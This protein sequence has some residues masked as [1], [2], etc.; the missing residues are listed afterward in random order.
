MVACPNKNTKDWKDLVNQIGEFEAYRQYISNNYSI[1]ISN[2]KQI[3]ELDEYLT[4]LLNNLGF[5]VKQDSRLLV[6]KDGNQLN[7][8]ARVNFLKKLVEVAQGRADE[9]T[10]PEES[11]HIIVELLGDDNLLIKSMM[12]KI[13]NYKLYDTTF[14]EYKS[15]PAYLNEDGTPNIDKIKK[16]AIGKL[17]AQYIVN[18]YKGEE[19]ESALKTAR[20]WW[21]SVK[22]IL[23][24]LLKSVNLNELA[25]KL[26]PFSEVAGKIL[27]GDISGEVNSIEEY[28][29]ASTDIQKS[30]ISGIEKVQSRI[31]KDEN[32]EIDRYTVDGQKG[33]KSATEVSKGDYQERMKGVKIDKKTQERY[34]SQRD[35][36]TL[37]H[38]LLA[39]IIASNFSEENKH[40]NRLSASEIAKNRSLYDALYYGQP[41]DKGRTGGLDNLINIAKVEGSVLM[42]EVMI[43]N[44]KTKRV[45]TIDLL[46]I[47]KDG[48][49]DIYDYKTRGKKDL[50]INKVKEYNKQINEYIKIL[51]AGDS[52]LGIIPGKVKKRRI[53]PIVTKTN[54][55]KPIN[56]AFTNPL[57]L[58]SEK[59]NI[60]ELDLFIQRLLDQIQALENKIQSRLTSEEKDKYQLQIVNK[61]NLIIRLQLTKD[62]TSIKEEAFK[63]LSSIDSLVSSSEFDLTRN[64][65][66]IN[67]ILT[68]YMDI[69]RYAPDE[70][71]K[72]IDSVLGDISTKALNIKN[73]LDVSVKEALIKQNEDTFTKEELLGPSVPTSIWTRMMHGVSFSNIPLVRS[74]KTLLDDALAKARTNT[75]EL[76][77]KI[78]E[79]IKEIMDEHGSFNKLLQVKADGSLTGNMVNELT[80]EFSVQYAKAK[81]TG[82]EEW[83]KENTV[84][85]EDKYNK[86]FNTRRTNI[87]KDE[88]ANKY[89]IIENLKKGYP[90]LSK[91]EINEKANNIIERNITSKLI[92]FENSFKSIIRFNKPIKDKWI[93]PMYTEIQNNPS[94]KKFYDLWTSTMEELSEIVPEH[95]GKNFIPN[96]TKDFIERVMD[97]GLTA[98]TDLPGDFLDSL[99]TKFDENKYGA[100]SSA[101][102][103]PIYTIPIKGLGYK[104]LIGEERKEFIETRKSYDLGE[105][106]YLFAESAYRAKEMSAIESTAQMSLYYLKR[107]EEQVLDNNGKPVTTYDIIKHRFTSG[108]AYKMAKDHIDNVVYGKKRAEED[109]KTLVTIKGRNVSLGQAT[110]LI[111]KYTGLKNLALNIISPLTDLLVNRTNVYA[112]GFGGKWYNIKDLSGSAT[113]ITGGPY[114][115]EEGEKAHLIADTIDI[116]TG[117]HNRERQKEVQAFRSKKIFTTDRLFSLFRFSDIINQNSVLIAMLKSS[118]HQFTWEDFE[119][120][121]KKL[122]W[123]E[124]GKQ[125]KPEEVE[126]FRQKVMKVNKQITG[127][128][129]IEDSPAVKRWFIGRIL[130]QHRGW[131]PAQLEQ[132]WG[133][134]R[135]D[136]DF[137]QFVEGRYRT[138]I[139]LLRE[140]IVNKKGFKI[141]YSELSDY[142]KANMRSNFLEASILISVFGLLQFLKGGDDDKE[143]RRKLA[144][145]IK[146]TARVENEMTFFSD[147]TGRSAYQILKS[148][149]ASMS[150]IEESYKLGQE[151]FKY[152][153]PE[154]HEKAKVG[155]AARRLV[156]AVRQIEY[157]YDLVIGEE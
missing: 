148:P 83:F 59:T 69:S 14:E 57:P 88:Q 29:Q 15:I 138:L 7:I 19:T 76:Q 17:I 71:K 116:L 147:F 52:T 80:H 35:A 90:D 24:K 42:A 136:Y 39:D 47:N 157:N 140:S 20:T 5:E 134:T 135:F 142:Q 128:Y 96:F 97:I 27:K 37:A 126:K 152:A 77:S 75:K 82:N 146:L 129:D 156:P 125:V 102:G 51:E 44:T 110:D 118:K 115:G 154:T 61:R 145:L 45:G 55:N 73:R 66:E 121:D 54:K 33:Y 2:N 49:Y 150:V 41:S 100:T 38:T 143:R 70:V 131:I 64:W 12:N 53:L 89:N 99:D 62:F 106:L 109:S 98:F 137:N 8:V 122:V 16:E 144:Y 30:I 28:Y 91:E 93:D 84:F 10:L 11:A 3:Q 123:K 68:F 58:I 117:E 56:F 72:G 151:L 23:Q 48:T 112:T 95:I 78:K 108:N 18:N 50:H 114:T 60:D 130:M 104:N 101:T 155:K 113:L 9:S 65:R 86:A 40:I 105:V 127:N 87:E 31:V 79:S 43:A 6:D 139:K 74:I 26:D 149:A 133:A 67:D 34:D 103:D 81:E 107:Q 132:R 13:T 25:S 1:P 85:D 124:T 141:G 120:K 63:D 32:A 119:V 111:I 92:D 94:L 153:N 22:K 46:K 4:S 21:E 36:G